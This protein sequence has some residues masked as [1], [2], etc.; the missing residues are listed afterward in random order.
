[1][2]DLSARDEWA[3]M[4]PIPF[5]AMLGFMGSMIPAYINGVMIAPMTAAFGWTRAEFSSGLAIQMGVVLLFSPLVGRTIDRFGSRRVA[6]VGLFPFVAAVAM[7]GLANGS[8]WQWRLLCVVEGMVGAFVVAPTWMTAV[9]IRFNASRG[10]AMAI[11]LAGV[12]VAAM[13]WP[14]AAT[15][16]VERLGWRL[17]FGAVTLSWAL[18]AYPIV[19]F[20]LR[21]PV[22]C[23]GPGSSK[24]TPH[25]FTAGLKALRS[26]VVIGV[27]VAGMLFITATVGLTLN[28]VPI[29]VGNGVGLKAAAGLA[30]IAGFSSLAGRMGTGFLLDRLSARTVGI[31]AFCVPVLVS[32]LLLQGSP[33]PW[34]CVLAM[35]LLG[36]AAGAETDVVTYLLSRQV[37]ATEFGSAYAIVTSVFAICAGVG[38]LIASAFYDLHHSYNSFLVAVIPTVLTGALLIRMTPAQSDPGDTGRASGEVPT[39]L[40]PQG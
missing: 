24:T 4:W 18:V 16:Y 9:V 35:T 37:P 31:T 10:L 7:L 30:G 22:Q 40:V 2:Q 23:A 8:I 12:G 29:L 6:L 28:S 15:I 1:M 14:I 19:F 34:I 20:C 39:G 13:V 26:R 21:D 3:T 5:V 25:D 38:P 11:A 32:L 33:A 36:L 27:I 17:T